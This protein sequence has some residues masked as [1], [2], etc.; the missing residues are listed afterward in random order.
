[1]VVDALSTSTFLRTVFA[2][3]LK[4]HAGLQHSNVISCV[5]D[6]GVERIIIRPNIDV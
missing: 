4:K 1:M 2:R 6:F 5:S 3:F